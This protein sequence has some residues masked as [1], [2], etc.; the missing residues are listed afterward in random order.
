MSEG[1][2]TRSMDVQTRMMARKSQN[3]Q[4]KSPLPNS[5]AKKP[6]NTSIK[7]KATLKTTKR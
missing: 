5:V 3:A 4:R 2:K 6:R 7:I 1:R